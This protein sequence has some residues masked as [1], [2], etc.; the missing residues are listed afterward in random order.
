M[1]A[2]SLSAILLLPLAA[3]GQSPSPETKP[4]P[5]KVSAEVR[6]GASGIEYSSSA[7]AGTGGSLDLRDDGIKTAPSTPSYESISSSMPSL[8]ASLQAKHRP[9]S[10]MLTLFF[11]NNTLKEVCAVLSAVIGRPV[12]HHA[13]AEVNVTR[14]Y[15]GVRVED[16]LADLCANYPL[17][18]VD[19]G[20]AL[21]MQDQVPVPIEVRARASFNMEANN[22]PATMTAVKLSNRKPHRDAM[23]EAALAKERWELLSQRAGYSHLTPQELPPQVLDPKSAAAAALARERYDLLVTRASEEAVPVPDEKKKKSLYDN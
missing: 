6:D 18:F 23:A 12:V 3:W 20:K 21:V 17:S 10:T 11:R 16:V 1:K 14:Q 13:I 5:E 9:S 15:V 4:A 2:H 8:P 7:L 22:K 19:D